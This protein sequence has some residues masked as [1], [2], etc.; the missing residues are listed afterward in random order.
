MY[1]CTVVVLPAADADQVP[2]NSIA[3]CAV[4]TR[5]VFCVPNRTSWF[6]V[7]SVPDATT[8]IRSS[9]LVFSVSPA[10]PTAEAL[11]TA[12]SHQTQVVAAVGASVGHGVAS[13]VPSVPG[14][15]SQPSTNWNVA[16]AVVAMVPL[17]VSRSARPMPLGLP[18]KKFAGTMAT[19]PVAGW[20]NTACVV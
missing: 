13:V 8:D 19:A 10:E 3:A 7:A 15:G 5:P 17:A 11:M 18:E 16:A 6:A 2:Q 20:E 12:S 1:C 14:V 4:A 9:P